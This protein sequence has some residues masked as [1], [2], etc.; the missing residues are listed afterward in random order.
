MLLR[1][2]YLIYFVLKKYKKKN[3]LMACLKKMCKIATTNT[4]TLSTMI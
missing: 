4:T 2:V 3:F 1:I